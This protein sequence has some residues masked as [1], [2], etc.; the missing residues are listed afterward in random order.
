MVALLLLLLCVIDRFFVFPIALYEYVRK[1]H[2]NGGWISPN[3][4]H[5]TITA[6][7]NECASRSGATYFAYNSNTNN[8]ACYTGTCPNDGKHQDHKAYRIIGPSKI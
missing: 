2:C 3:T 7:R 5:G 8:C 1:G 6:C 4:N